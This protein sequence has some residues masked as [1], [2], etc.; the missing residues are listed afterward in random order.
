MNDD[1]TLIATASEKGTLINV[2]DLP[3]AQKLHTLRRGSTPATIHSLSFAP[4][5]VRPPLLAASGSHGTVH[6]FKLENSSK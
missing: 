5:S 2:Y 3:S 1:S 4:V 6:V